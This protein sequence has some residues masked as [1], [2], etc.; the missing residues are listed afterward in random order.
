MLS[1]FVL[2]LRHFNYYVVKLRGLLKPSSECLFL[3]T[4]E[5]LKFRMQVLAPLLWV[6]VMSVPLSRP[7]LFGSAFHAQ[8]GE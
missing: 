3:L 4:S 2:C 8:P 7:L 1:N 6:V 5:V